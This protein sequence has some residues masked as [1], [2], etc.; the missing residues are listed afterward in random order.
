AW[1]G[2]SGPFGVDGAT[3]YSLQA[4]RHRTD[5]KSSIDTRLLP[6]ADPDRD[7]FRNT[8]FTGSLGHRL[9]TRH[10]ICARIFWSESE[11]GLD[12]SFMVGPVRV[13]YPD[14]SLTAASAWLEV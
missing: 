8:S 13:E 4:R 10:R 11:V 9:S 1:A 6:G 7:G 2:S 3:D 12:D 5:G 14:L